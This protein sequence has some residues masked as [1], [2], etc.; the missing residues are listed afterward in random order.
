M[1]VGTEGV[2][3]FIAEQFHG[4]LGMTHA[5]FPDIPKRS[6]IRI[7][8]ERCPLVCLVGMQLRNARRTRIV[9]LGETKSAGVRQ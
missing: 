6:R 3:P 2:R 5:Q 7:K 9:D 8:H 1:D 4:Y